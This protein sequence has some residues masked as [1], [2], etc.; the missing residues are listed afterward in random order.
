MLIGFSSFVE[1][2]FKFFC[3]LKKC[4][5]KKNWFV[6]VLFVSDAFWKYLL[7]SVACLFILLKEFSDEHKFW[8][9]VK[10]NLSMLFPMVS[11]FAILV[12]NYFPTQAILWC[13]IFIILLSTFRAAIHLKLNLV[14]GHLWTWNLLLWKGF[15]L[16]IQY[17]ID[18]HMFYLFIYF[19]QFWLVMFFRDVFISPW[20]LNVLP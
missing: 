1:G 6:G 16:Q 8:I 20:L 15:C 11:T 14:Y 4:C 17:L 2:L 18:I 19:G 10:S 3:S 13:H 5:L 12:K 9:W 7:P